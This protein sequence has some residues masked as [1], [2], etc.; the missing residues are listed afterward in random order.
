VADLIEVIGETEL[1]FDGRSG[2][3]EITVLRERIPT[4]AYGSGTLEALVHSTLDV[5]D[6]VTFAVKAYNQSVSPE[7]PGVLFVGSTPIAS[8][9]FDIP[10]GA[11]APA[12]LTDGLSGP[13]APLV[14]VVLEWSQGGVEASAAQKV[15]LSARLI[16]RRG[17]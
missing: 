6:S 7:E 3:T 5:E 10:G 13:I 1:A 14:R 11:Q 17:G 8:A 15:T 9:V 4:L 16:M 12:L 2:S